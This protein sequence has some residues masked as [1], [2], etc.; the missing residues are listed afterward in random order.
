MGNTAD[1][2]IVQNAILRKLMHTHHAA[3][4]VLGNLRSG[5]CGV[6]QRGFA[7]Y[8]RNIASK[9]LVAGMGFEPMTFRL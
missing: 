3:A 2:L 5:R 9:K 1:E 6:F 8:R 7:I 4:N